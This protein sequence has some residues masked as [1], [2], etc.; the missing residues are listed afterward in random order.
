MAAKS[1]IR[2]EAPTPLVR[3]GFRAGAG[4]TPEWPGI[5]A[6]VAAGKGE[7]FRVR[8]YATTNTAT[9]SACLVRKR[10]DREGRFEFAARTVAG[11]GVLY[12]RLRTEAK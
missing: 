8:E 5:L 3:G 9:S 7:W 1:A 4:R 12:A 10:Y 6:K 2:R 11:R